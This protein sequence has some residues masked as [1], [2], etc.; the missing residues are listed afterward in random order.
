MGRPSNPDLSIPWKL[1]LSAPIAGRLE[2][3]LADPIHSKPKYGARRKLTEAL[4]EWWIARESGVPEN[5]RPSIP[6]VQEL[7]EV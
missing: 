5:Q 2:L 4:Y 1:L 3:M 6:S 7:R